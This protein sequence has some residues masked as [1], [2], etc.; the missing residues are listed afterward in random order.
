MELMNFFFH[1]LLMR[2]RRADAG[3]IL[4]NAKPPVSDDVV[5]AHVASE[6]MIN[7][8]LQ[9]REFVRGYRPIEIDDISQTTIAK[10]SRL[11]YAVY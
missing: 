9:R 3:D 7:G 4:V 5:Y 2:D 1:E 6:G 11:H 10:A 8:R